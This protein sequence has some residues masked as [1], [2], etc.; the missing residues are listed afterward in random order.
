MGLFETGM[1]P[2]SLPASLASACVR[3]MRLSQSESIVR[4]KGSVRARAIVVVGAWG[5]GAA[6]AGLLAPLP[7]AP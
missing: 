6:N 7:S 4:D 5:G 2:P 1:E 3:L